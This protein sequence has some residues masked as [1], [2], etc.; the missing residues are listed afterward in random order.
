[1]RSGRIFHLR[2]SAK[3]KIIV[4]GQIVAQLLLPIMTTFPAHA[5]QHDIHSNSASMPYG[6]TMSTLASAISDNGSEGLKSAA[7]N[8]ATGAAASTVEEWLNNFGTAKVNLSVDNDGNWDQSSIDLLTPI[9][10]NKKAVWFTQF[11]LRAPDDRVTGNIGTGVRTFYTENWMFGG[12]IFFDNDFTGKNRRVGFGAEAWTNYLKLSAN[13][14]VG[15]TNWHDSRDFD[16]YYEK[17]ADG[18]DIRAEA[19]LPE[20]PQVGAKAMYEK[21]YGNNVA[22]FDTDHLQSNPSAV[23]LGISYTPIPLVSLATN[24]R[25]GQDSMDDAQ[26]QVNVRY[27]FGHDWRYQVNPDNVRAMRTLAGSRYDL[28]ERNN[29]IIL[30]Y[31]K[32]EEQGVSKLAIQ[33][34]TDNSPADGLTQNTLQAIAT[35]RDNVPVANAPITWATTGNARVDTPTSV[36]NSQ[37]IAIVNLTNTTVEAVQVTANS[38]AVAASMTSHF[39][40]VAVS[41]LALA[42]TK[43][44]SVADGMTPNAAVATVT[45]INNRPIA[46]TKVSWVVSSPAVLKNADVSTD[47]NGQ[48]RTEFISTQAGPATLKVSAGDMMAEQ[49]SSFVSNSANAQITDFT[50]TTNNSPANG[51]TPNMALITVK[52]TNGNAVSNVNVSVTA[53]KSTVSFIALKSA[54]TAGAAM[55]TDVNG[56]LRVALTDSVVEAVTLTA[57][58]DNGN[59]RTASVQFTAD[60]TTAQIQDLKIIKDKS[61]ANGSMANSAEVYVRDVNGNAV[62]GAQVNWSADK[63]TAAFSASAVTDVS[64]KTTVQFTDS[65]AE[66]VTIKAQ[67]ANGSSMTASS[68][69]IADT[70]TAQLQD[71]LVTKN[72]SAANGS[73]ANTAQVYVKDAAGN[74]IQNQDVTWSVDKTGITLVSGGKTDATGKTTVSYTSTVAQTFQLTATLQNGNQLSASSL[75]IADSASEKISAFIVTSGAVANG[76]AT[77]TATVTVTDANNNPVQNVAVAWSADGS[78]TL[79]SASDKTDAAGQA[80]ITITDL[81]SETVNITVNL[82][83]GVSQTKSVEFIADSNSAKISTFTVTTG[84]IADGTTTNSGNVSIV[85]TNN[86]PVANATV[87]WSVT[88]SAK[89]SAASSSTDIDG[90]AAI[91]ITDTKAEDVTL[92]VTVNGS[93]QGKAMTFVADA[94]KA[95]IQSLTL[96]TN[97]SAANGSA[98]NKATITVVDENGNPVANQTIGWSADKGTVTLTPS[99]KTDMAGKAS[100]TFSD[101]K[102]ETVS[103]TATLTN[104]NHAS[105]SSLFVADSTTATVVSIIVNPNNNLADGSGTN[106]ATA[107]VEDANGN[108]LQGQVVTWSAD[109]TSVKL[110]P[111]GNTDMNGRA[112]VSLTDTVGGVVN[113][114]ATLNNGDS[115]TQQANFLAI[116]LSALSSDLTT[117]DADGS[118]G[119]IFTATLKDS[120]GAVVSNSPVAFIV[121]SG[122]GTLS[123]A[124]AISNASG[125]ATVKLT[126]TTPGSVTVS[127][128]SK[129]NASDPGQSRTVTFTEMKFTDIQ[130]NGHSYNSNAGFPQTGFVGATFQLYINDDTSRNTVYDWTA[131]QNWVSVDSTGIV[132]FTSSPDAGSRSVTI[133]AT[134]KSGG[135]PLVYSFSIQHW[136]SN[137]STTSDATTA[138]S[139]CA[140]QGYSAAPYKLLTNAAVNSTGSRKIGTLWGE[141]GSMGAYGNGWKSDAYWAQEPYT[142]PGEY[143]GVNLSSGY[144]TFADENHPYYTVCIQ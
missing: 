90:N 143:Y 133:S 51:T 8:A 71:L 106:V 23:T 73:D 27:D 128:K 131:S 46:N 119:I 52:D 108:P 61:T 21:Y 41:N 82:D 24:Y 116:T 98:Q 69:F 93:S 100:V 26:F 47:A 14:Y 43:D 15:T 44:G 114:T 132:K 12:N 1:M 67:L 77:N 2:F 86:N 54:R 76:S 10:D 53:D 3:I 130:V 84:A 126:A 83:S 136:F 56:Q 30:Q 91:T 39:N 13:S 45:D 137:Q 99:G 59:T 110:T 123:A 92:T 28:I 104:G 129:I 72:G 70:A 109:R 107:L 62:S 142:T 138:A 19:Y 60:A 87:T 81:K 115:G 75:F 6:D 35:N 17:P 139:R 36:T 74:P 38:G 80:K 127:A 11:G 89:V 118:D 88:G 117:Q 29:Q 97:S 101:T 85:D 48:A 18:F 134:P 112:S 102:A 5:V 63:P 25:K 20:Y 55:Q 31:K 66:A 120:S 32:K 79:S 57:S 135:T 7:Q 105:V 40:A 22:L 50:V 140:A 113:I 94:S 49:K 144:L 64:G 96:D 33:A 95:V 125:Q 78:A 16:D 9:Y 34:I 42:I 121:T 58:L 103:I 37:G 111:A 4:W 122:S 124:E 65:V 141:W 68:S